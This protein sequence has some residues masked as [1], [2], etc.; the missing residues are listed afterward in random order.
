VIRKATTRSDW[1]DVPLTGAAVDALIAQAGRRRDLLG[2]V[3]GPEDYVIPR[4]HRRWRAD[5]A[6][7]CR[8]RP[9][10]L[11]DIWHVPERARVVA[12]PVTSPWLAH[13]R[14]FIAPPLDVDTAGTTEAPLDIDFAPSRA[15][16]PLIAIHD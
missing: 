10:V 4:R 13:D 6:L 7:L 3:S 15:I 1:R 9:P 12:V 2:V 5:A 8:Q 11:L 14:G 16:H